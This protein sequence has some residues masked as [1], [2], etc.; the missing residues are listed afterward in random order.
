LGG[1]ISLVGMVIF[2]EFMAAFAGI[3]GYGG[4]GQGNWVLCF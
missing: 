1:T 2:D 3:W 4:F